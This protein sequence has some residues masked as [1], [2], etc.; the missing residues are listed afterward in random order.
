MRN[1]LGELAA[2]LA[3]A[4]SSRP[5]VDAI[6]A[7]MGAA[8][9]TAAFAALVWRVAKP[10]VERWARSL[11]A[12]VVHE[13]ETVAEHAVAAEQAASSADAKIDQ[14][15]DAVDRVNTRVRVIDGRSLN[16]AG[17]VSYLRRLLVAHIRESNEVLD[18][19]RANDLDLP[20]DFTEPDRE[21]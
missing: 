21:D 12:A 20:T 13:R 15:V 9:L 18:M 11:V 4:A 5:A 19:L 17:S 1:D 14:L 6:L 8:T 7:G 10:H 16:N 2:L 3:A